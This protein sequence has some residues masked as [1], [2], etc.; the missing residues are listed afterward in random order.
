MEG[1]ITKD[2][3]LTFQNLPNS[4]HIYNFKSSNLG[5]FGGK[6]FFKQGQRKLSLSVHFSS[7]SDIP[8]S[9]NPLPSLQLPNT[10]L[11]SV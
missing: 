7:F 10:L 1:R 9:L 3:Q 11:E 8:F 6:S 4:V 2:F 5:D